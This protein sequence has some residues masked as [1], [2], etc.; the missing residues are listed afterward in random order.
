MSE[1]DYQKY[2][3]KTLFGFFFW[4]HLL[5]EFIFVSLPFLIPWWLLAVLVGLLFLQFKIFG[6]CL[7]NKVHFREDDDAV[8]LYPYLKML[9]VNIS[10]PRAKLFLRYILPILL[11]GVAIIWQVILQ[12]GVVWSVV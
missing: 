8:F 6:N 4:S 1:F 9:G 11:I 10:Y 12:K 7:I 2:D 3:K 5:L